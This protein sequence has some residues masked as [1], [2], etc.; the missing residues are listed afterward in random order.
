SLLEQMLMTLPGFAAG[1]DVAPV[2]ELVGAIPRLSGSDTA[3]PAVL[4]EF[5][6]GEGAG[7]PDRLRGLYE[8]TRARRGL[9]RPGVKFITDRAG[10]NLWHLGLIKLLY[11]EAPIIH[12]VRHP[13]DVMLA[14]FAQDR[15]LEANCQAGMPALARHYALSM[16]MVRHYRGQLTLRYLPVRYEDLV[17]T[18]AATLR[19]VLDFV[20]SDAPV[21]DAATLAANAAPV[22]EPMP[23]HVAGREAL[24]SRAAWRHKGYLA[25]MPTLFDEIREILEPWINALGYSKEGAP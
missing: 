12:V 23:A 14:N 24:H 7:L 10:S 15:K 13:Y 22:P 21:P 18:P 19:R 20:G 2:E 6:V 9:L 17:A 4:D 3:Y 11:P 5:L 1:D 16:D 8:Q 25:Q